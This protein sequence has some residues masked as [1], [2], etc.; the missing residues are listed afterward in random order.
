[1][2]VNIETV[3]TTKIK[4]EMR[5]F[6]ALVI[7]SLMFGGL[8]MAFGVAAITNNALALTT[9]LSNVLLNVPLI[10]VGAFVAYLGIRY[11]I[12]TAEVMSKFDEIQEEPIEKNPTREK[13]TERI[14]KLMGLYRDEKPQITRMV[15]IS[16]IAGVCFIAY[17]LIQTIIFIFSLLTGATEVFFSVLGIISS[18]VMG[19][20]GFIIPSF[21]KNYSVCWDKRLEKSA[22]AEK[23]IASFMEE[24]P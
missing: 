1:M 21:F 13:L 2:E 20:V 5:S 18:F 12:S 11:L 14:V 10:V 19:A 24:N 4:R 9:T 6:L 8:A 17:A 22:E 3:T 7:V 16:K 15:S 23:K